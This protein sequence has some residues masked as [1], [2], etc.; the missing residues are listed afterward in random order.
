MIHKSR[1]GQ[2]IKWDKMR[3]LQVRLSYLLYW[4]V[5]IPEIPAMEVILLVKV[6]S[7]DSRC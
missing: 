3:L 5:T 7:L 1:N 4:H 6:T 2:L